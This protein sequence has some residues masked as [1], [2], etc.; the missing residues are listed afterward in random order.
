MAAYLDLNVR[1][2]QSDSAAAAAAKAAEAAKRA[3]MLA[4]LDQQVDTAMK[5]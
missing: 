1:V 2:L 4:D 3:K 5:S